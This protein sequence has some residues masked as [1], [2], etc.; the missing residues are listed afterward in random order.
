[1]CGWR[2]RF[3]NSDLDEDILACPKCHGELRRDEN[4]FICDSCELK[5]PIEDGIPNFLI[6]EA[7]SF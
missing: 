6:D 4:Y 3:L 7:E 1:M 2:L 5:F